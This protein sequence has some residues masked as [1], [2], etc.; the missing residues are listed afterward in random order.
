MRG[1]GCA[2]RGSEPDGIA[3][4]QTLFDTHCQ[5]RKEEITGAGRIDLVAGRSAQAEEAFRRALRLEPSNGRAH[6]YLG[7]ALAQQGRLAEAVECWE[8]WLSV[9]DPVASGDENQ[10]D[11]REAVEAAQ[12]LAIFLQETHG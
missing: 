9:H 1:A 2:T 7:N 8:R 5:S 11:V 4:T 6:R 10:S 3:R 12:R